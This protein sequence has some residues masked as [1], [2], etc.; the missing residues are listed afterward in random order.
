VQEFAPA[1]PIMRPPAA[2]V[3]EKAPATV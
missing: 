3:N 2:P 1:A